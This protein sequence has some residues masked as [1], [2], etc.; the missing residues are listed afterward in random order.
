[1]ESEHRF[2]GADERG[3]CVICQCDF[4]EE[5]ELYAGP[6]CHPLHRACAEE[7]VRQA[8]LNWAS[9]GAPVVAC[10]TCKS[11]KAFGM[12]MFPVDAP[13]MEERE[14]RRRAWEAAR[15]QEVEDQQLA[16]ELF[17]GEFGFQLIQRRVS[18]RRGDMAVLLFVTEALSG[19][20]PPGE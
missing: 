7:Y 3:L 11:E 8:R 19:E 12:A 20:R 18:L 9:A 14:R 1:M 2:Y 15:R 5:D 10:P 4:E 17:H 13:E 6:C 16:R